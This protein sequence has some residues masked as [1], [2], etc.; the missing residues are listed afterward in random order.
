MDR[1]LPVIDWFKA[2]GMLLIVMGHTNGYLVNDFTKPIGLKQIGVALFFFIMG[3][4][5]SIDKRQS[6]I[7]LFNRLFKI[8]F[9]SLGF[10]IL[11]SFIGI[12]NE[13]KIY[14]SNYLPFFIGVNTLLNDFPA[15]QATWFIGTYMHLLILWVVILKEI[16]ISQL[17]ILV[18]VATEILIRAA[19][20]PYWGHSAYMM[21]VNWQTIFILGIYCGQRAETHST[22]L[23][24]SIAMYG[25]FIVLWALAFSLVDM[26]RDFPFKIVQ[27]SDMK[28]NYLLTSCLVSLSYSGHVLLFYNVAM[29]LPAIGLVRFFSQ[30]SLILFLAHMPVWFFITPYI[31]AIIDYNYIRVVVDFAILYLGLSLVSSALLRF[32]PIDRFRENML[33]LISLRREKSYL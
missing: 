25:G 20:M 24:V 32:V 31:K 5:I 23:A 3:W 4:Q 9:W 12:I 14:K 13:G 2:I 8:I 21:F 1:Q 11:L 7:I 33:N 26:S 30:N 27:I 19:I 17:F 29:N 22:G 6:K 10:A 16:T 15:N 28:T 18:V